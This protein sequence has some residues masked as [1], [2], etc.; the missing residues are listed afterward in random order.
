MRSCGILRATNISENVSLKLAFKSSRALTAGFAYSNLTKFSCCQVKR[1]TH[2]FFF[3]ILT[4][5][6][7]FFAMI[8]LLAFWFTIDDN[9]TAKAGNHGS[10]GIV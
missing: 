8:C 1:T 3:R 4:N 6:I 5:I 7:V 9:R 2:R 10:G